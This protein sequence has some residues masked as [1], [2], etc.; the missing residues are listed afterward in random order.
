MFHF[1][2]LFFMQVAILVLM[3]LFLQKLTQV[4]RQVDD[5]TR[6]VTNYISY[7]TNDISE[8]ISQANAP[9]KKKAEEEQNR[10]IQAVLEEYFP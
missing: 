10:L 9:I 8:E 5:I 1:E 2:C 7:I 6:E 3:I 4:K